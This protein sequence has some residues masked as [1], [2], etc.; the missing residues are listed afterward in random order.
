M[1]LRQLGHF[2]RVDP[3]GIMIGKRA[4]IVIVGVALLAFG[5]GAGAASAVLLGPM[6]LRAAS[7]NPTPSLVARATASPS[8]AGRP[9]PSPLQ[10]PSATAPQP[11]S[12]PSIGLGAPRPRVNASWAFDQATSTFV[13]FGGYYATGAN[14]E[15]SLVLGDT[16]TWD[17]AQWTQVQLTST[18]PAARWEGSMDYD[19]ARNVVFLHGGRNQNNGWTFND[20][21]TWEGARWRLLSPDQNPPAVGSQPMS[22]DSDRRLMLLFTGT[23]NLQL[24]GAQAG[25]NQTWSW[26][27]TTWSQLPA[28]EAPSGYQGAQAEMAYDQARGTTV[29][30]GHV[31]GQA[32][33]W[34]FDGTNWTKAASSSGSD[35]IY[36]AMAPNLSRADVVLFG[37]NGDTWT[38][39]GTKWSAQNPAHSPPGRRGAGMAYDSVHNVDI[40]FGGASGSL[41]SYKELNDVWTWNG[42]D[43]TQVSPTS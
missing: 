30:F 17:G 43:W 36:F 13:L 21:W 8:S 19:R 6:H 15:F 23:G 32:A 39:D 14:H 7:A 33:T 12:P 27:G 34:T 37:E 24:S 28:Q 1:H 11:G 10:L 3:P 9:I 20:N 42:M 26:D 35:S 2:L 25:V 16:W 18:S 4:W 40:L 29:L 38:W 41:S 5:S 31:S 22:W